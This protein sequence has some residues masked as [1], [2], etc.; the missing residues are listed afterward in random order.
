MWTLFVFNVSKMSE[1]YVK[2]KMDEKEIK[3]KSLTLNNR[4][5]AM[6]F[7]LNLNQG[8]NVHFLGRRGD[9]CLI[10]YWLLPRQGLWE[11]V[12]FVNEERMNANSVF[13]VGQST[14]TVLATHLPEC[15]KLQREHKSGIDSRFSSLS[16]RFEQPRCTCDY[17]ER[18]SGKIDQNL[19]FV[20]RVEKSMS[21][22]FCS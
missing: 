3:L 21:F 2:I 7:R 11:D 20:T 19:N 1:V 22:I 17:Y 14:T 9:N 5:L 16:H 6:I 8:I 18:R 4:N 15:N 13:S 10:R 12:C